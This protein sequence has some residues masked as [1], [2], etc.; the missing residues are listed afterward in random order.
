MNGHAESRAPIWPCALVGVL[1]FAGG[2][3][4]V[5]PALHLKTGQSVALALGVAALSIAG[6][7]VVLSSAQ[8]PTPQR[9]RAGAA[10]SLLA[11]ILFAV[12][13]VLLQ[14]EWFW[15]VNASAACLFALHAGYYTR[16][17]RRQPRP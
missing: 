4:F 9:V 3:L 10:L 5:G 15:I 12:A 11:A 1:V 8:T 17:A 13:A 14:D 16:L 7:R 6:M 2:S